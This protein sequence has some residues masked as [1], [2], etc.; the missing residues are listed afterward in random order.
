MDVREKSGVIN[1]VMFQGKNG[2]QLSAVIILRPY[3]TLHSESQEFVIEVMIS[4]ANLYCP[5]LSNHQSL[6]TDY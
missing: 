4:E 1:T 5:L 2:G 3:Y 6:I